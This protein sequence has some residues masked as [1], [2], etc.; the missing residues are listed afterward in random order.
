MHPGTE[1]LL[2]GYH[3][4]G[5]WVF[6]EQSG[7]YRVLGIS[8]ELLLIFLFLWPTRPAPRRWVLIPP[9]LLLF[10]A[11]TWQENGS[12]FY[13]LAGMVLI[14][15][16]IFALLILL[17]YRLSPL[18]SLV[19]AMVFF[20]L[21]LPV[22]WMV[23]ACVLFLPYT[24]LIRFFPV[25][26]L[27]EYAPLRSLV[28]FLLQL[29]CV[30]WC[31]CHTPALEIETGNWINCLMCP[32]LILFYLY[33]RYD[34]KYLG[35]NE[36]SRSFE[37]FMILAAYLAIILITL[38]VQRVLILQRVQVQQNNIIR[39]GQEQYQ[40]VRAQMQMGDNVRKLYHDMHHHLSAIAALASD[41]QKVRSYIQSIEG[42]LVQPSAAVQ[43]GDAMLDALLGVRL[44]QASAEQIKLAVCVDFR[45]CDFLDPVDVCAIF[46][47]GVDNA[48]EA[49]RK[50]KGPEKR[51][52]LVKGGLHHGALLIKISNYYEHALRLEGERFLTTKPNR[53]FHGIGLSSIRY[54]VEKY[55]GEM[56][57]SRREHIFTLRILIP[58][59]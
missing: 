50:V 42:S 47:N 2:G 7:L 8:S 46:C 26:L 36:D 44:Q 51:R 18:R 35:F 19:L 55:H 29:L 13:N 20:L 48:L 17:V 57:I 52:I 10:L 43:T 6:L 53:E 32:M 23:S 28:F 24:P 41:D 1:S 4:N 22:R 58:Q 5:F 30:A 21:T 49:S 25:Q 38:L 31:S 56:T 16:A 33:L 11:V 27:V 54:S 40:N 14:R 3:V 12:S 9:F 39:L 37:L 15:L 59:P 34:L 45:E